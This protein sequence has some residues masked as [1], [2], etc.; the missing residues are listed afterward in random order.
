MR[1][2]YTK[3]GTALDNTYRR[4]EEEVLADINRLSGRQNPVNQLSKETPSHSI[5]YIISYNSYNAH[6]SPSPF[7][8]IPPILRQPCKVTARPT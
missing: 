6:A 8:S 3:I 2:V 1:A 4:L 7:S 5:K